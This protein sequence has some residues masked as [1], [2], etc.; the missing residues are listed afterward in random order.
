[1]IQDRDLAIRLLNSLLD[2]CLI[3]DNSAYLVRKSKSVSKE[4]EKEYC[5]IVGKMMAHVPCGVQVLIDE[6][7]DIAPDGFKPTKA[8]TKSKA[9]TK[10][11]KK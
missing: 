10:A 1:M 11:T 4:D 5:L 3:L 9:K 2:A 6:H 7:P 8:K